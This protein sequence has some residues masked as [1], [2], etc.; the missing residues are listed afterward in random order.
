M[1]QQLAPYRPDVHP[2][3]R[4]PLL[5]T[6]PETVPTVNDLEATQS[7]LTALKRIALERAKKAVGDLKIIEHE[8]KKMRELEKGKARAVP[9]QRVKRESS[10]A[11]NVVI[12]G[13]EIY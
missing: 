5:V 13:K 3:L 12:H 9:P 7:E 11:C 8:M 6:P 10:C 1:S 2:P 4:N